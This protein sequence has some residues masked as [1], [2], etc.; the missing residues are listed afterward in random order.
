MFNLAASP[1]RADTHLSE[2]SLGRPREGAPMKEARRLPMPGSMP[3]LS[4]GAAPPEAVAPRWPSRRGSRLASRVSPLLKA[5]ASTLPCFSKPPP[6][7]LRRLDPPPL[8]SSSL[9]MSS[10]RSSPW[11]ATASARASEEASLAVLDES[12][13]DSA[14]S[15]ASLEIPP[16]SIS[17][18][19]IASAARSSRL[20]SS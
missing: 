6:P 9:S 11:A 15:S 19:M 18:S 14:S 2:L 4:P 13:S 5:G 17:S 20:C 12:S 7:P 3:L 8:L 16:R 1:Q 10:S